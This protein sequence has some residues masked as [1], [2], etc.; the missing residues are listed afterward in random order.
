MQNQVFHSSGTPGNFNEGHSKKDVSDSLVAVKN[1]LTDTLMALIKHESL[2]LPI[3]NRFSHSF[4]FLLSVPII[5][6]Q[7]DGQLAL[8]D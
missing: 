6:R 5:A 7:N 1:R 3:P 2:S 8:S 4:M